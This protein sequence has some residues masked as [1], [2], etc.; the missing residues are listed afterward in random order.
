MAATTTFDSI[1]LDFNAWEADRIAATA[2]RIF[3]QSRCSERQ[4]AAYGLRPGSLQAA[5]HDA[6]LR[7]VAF[8]AI[9]ERAYHLRVD[10]VATFGQ[11]RDQIADAVAVK[12]A[13]RKRGA[14]AR[15]TANKYGDDFVRRRFGFTVAH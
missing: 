11:A 10:P 2:R 6:I 7:H 13:R 9:I 12:A 1:R 3:E 5:D 4:I 15:A 14:G 8:C